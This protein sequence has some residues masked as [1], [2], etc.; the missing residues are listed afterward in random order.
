MQNEMDNLFEIIEEVKSFL[1]RL[2][3]ACDSV[4]ELFYDKM[5]GQSWEVFSQVLAGIDDLY[6]T[7]G[8]VSNGLVNLEVDLAIQPIINE[9]N[10]ELENKIYEL[11]NYLDHNRHIAAGDI[12][13]HEIIPLIN[14]MSVSLGEENQ[15]MEERYERNLLTLMQLFPETGNQI[16]QIKRDEVN[17][18]LIPA[19]NGMS[20]IY[21]RNE[22]GYMVPIYS[23]YNP[24][25]EVERWVE[26]IQSKV[27][28]NS[29][30]IMFGFG[31]GYHLSELSRNLDMKV[32]VVEPDE[33][34]FLAAMHT[35]ELESIL[36]L[37]NIEKIVLGVK[38]SNLEEILGNLYSVNDIKLSSIDIPMYN[39]LYS[40]EKLRLKELIHEAV[41][42]YL[43]NISTMDSLGLRHTKNILFNVAANLATPSIT[44]YYKSLNGIS[45]V[46]VGAGPSLEKDID[47]IRELKK[48]AV[49]IAA[50]SSI[51][52]L[53]YYGIAPHFIVSMDGG[54]SN[55]N[56]FKD[57]DRKSIPL[58]Y[59]PQI[60]YR[61]MDMQYEGSMHAFFN[62]DS[63]TAYIMGTLHP[64]HSNFSV[65]GT[66]I[67]MAAYLGCTEVI[68]TGQDL[69]YPTENMY[70]PGAKHISSENLL[71]VVAKAK[72]YVDNVQGGKNRT[73]IK[74]RA[75]LAN[76]EKEIERAVNVEFINASRLG[77]R[78]EHTRFEPM[79]SVLERLSMQQQVGE[80]IERIVSEQAKRYD[81]EER[82]EI[83]SRLKNMP[84]LIYEVDVKVKQVK[85]RMG[86]LQELSRT[87]PE[88]C[89]KSMGAIE[90][91]WGGIVNSRPFEV[92]YV[93]VIGADVHKFDRKL[94]EL[95]EERNI[96]RKA[97]LFVDVL[98]KLIDKLEETNKHLFVY[99][100]EAIARV[101][102]LNLI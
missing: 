19:K 84:T 37:T 6:K 65:T 96:Q 34:V 22:A 86:K 102:R 64:F 38:K 47:L 17:Y 76:I 75:T 77:A 4:S 73:D 52:S 26:I 88:K 29:K 93:Y 30:S 31:L 58:I 91:I 90:D 74:M 100:E 16:R 27:E 9:F 55:Y 33:Q 46:I 63:I 98:G 48:Y 25:Y 21:V 45:A 23:R 92:L 99:F 49:I 95:S 57:I 7:L 50:G 32:I 3:R 1:P 101:E 67:Q 79:E 35:I 15:V 36:K 18:Q 72:D 85:R 66:A 68:F 51:Q 56:V 61:I 89:L 53:Q 70:S 5:D 20:N 94:P 97:Q 62:S 54:E 13:K 40:S 81:L 71:N 87:N 60:E 69:S 43:V 11:N 78:I 12:I 14:A 10:I 59:N 39:E 82:I 41:W 80:K 44:N 83:I 28:E 42:S 8:M 2:L 24:A